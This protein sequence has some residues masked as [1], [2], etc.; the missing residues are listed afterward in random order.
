[1]RILT[2]LAFKD[3]LSA[4]AENLME[5]KIHTH[6]YTLTFPRQIF[7]KTQKPHERMCQN[8]IDSKNTREPSEHQCYLIACRVS[9]ST[10]QCFY[11]KNA[12]MSKLLPGLQ[13]LARIK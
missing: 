8:T 3:Q 10:L 9:T 11:T 2:K 12:L 7:Q 13:K 4:I 6:P 1:M 5:L